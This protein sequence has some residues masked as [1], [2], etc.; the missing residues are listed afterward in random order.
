MK[1]DLVAVGDNLIT[2]TQHN[3]PDGES[4]DASGVIYTGGTS[5]STALVTGA[6]GF[7][8]APAQA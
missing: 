2:A 4:F 6:A 3:H 8:K 1:P 5:F 7:L